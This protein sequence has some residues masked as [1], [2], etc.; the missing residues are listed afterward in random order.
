MH[1]DGTLFL[2]AVDM[3]HV[4]MHAGRLCWL[5]GLIS[6]QTFWKALT[7]S[8]DSCMEIKSAHIS[9]ITN[10]GR[11]WRKGLEYNAWGVFGPDPDSWVWPL[12]ITVCCCTAH[13]SF[14]PTWCHSP[15]P[16]CSPRWTSMAAGEPEQLDCAYGESW[17][18]KGDNGDTVESNTHP[19]KWAVPLQSTNKESR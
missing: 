15:G 11:V 2:P 8:V 14:C 3:P 19:T 18:K 13:L 6:T 17:W 4:Y 9:G 1:R 10:S 12:T 16:T 7:A 5:Q